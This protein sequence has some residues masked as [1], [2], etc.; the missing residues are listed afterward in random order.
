MGKVK[1]GQEKVKKLHLNKNFSTAIFIP[2]QKK[3]SHVYHCHP[4][5][6]QWEIN[7]HTEGTV[8]RF[9]SKGQ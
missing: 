6:V 2:E 4:A 9:Y 7:Q 8:R 1:Q 5:S 3:A